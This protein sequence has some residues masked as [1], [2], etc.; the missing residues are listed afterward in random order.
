VRAGCA[1]TNRYMR[2]S[3]RRVLSPSGRLGPSPAAGFA[4]SCTHAAST[5][6]R[7]HLGTLPGRRGGLITRG[8][9]SMR[10]GGGVALPGRRPLPAIHTLSGNSRLRTLAAAR[11]RSLVRAPAPPPRHVTGGLTG[12]A[13][14]P[15]AEESVSGR[16]LRPRSA[17]SEEKRQRPPQ[18]PTPR[19]GGRWR[20]ESPG[21]DHKR[22]RD[23]AAFEWTPAR[24]G[25][26]KTPGACAKLA[27]EVGPTSE[28]T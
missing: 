14:R 15:C 1:P 25:P 11:A 24:L 6:L 5:L 18:G 17:V 4:V 13:R 12:P 9:R 7:S 8:G 10:T 19:C 23:R 27:T 28:A 20:T 21:S 16:W 22:R 26:R 2:S 3:Q